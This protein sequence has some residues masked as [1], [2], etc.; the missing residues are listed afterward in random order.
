MR[1]SLLGVSAVVILALAWLGPLDR[2]AQDYVESGLKRALITFAAA[3]TANAVISV[4]Q[5]T[6]VAIQPLGV[7]VT[8]SPAQ[9]LDPHVRSMEHEARAGVGEVAVLLC[10]YIDV[11]QLACRK[12]LLAWNAVGDCREDA[13]TGNARKAVG[14]FWRRLR[15]FLLEQVCANGVQLRRRHAGLGG[16]AH[17]FER[18]RD[19][20]A[21]VLEAVELVFAVDGH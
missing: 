12:L 7:G 2:V 5:E 9:A 1:R 18:A 15:A 19:D 21:D 11:D 10:R 3:R 16:G 13:D 6:T 8:L 14:K 20:A 17:G 4:V